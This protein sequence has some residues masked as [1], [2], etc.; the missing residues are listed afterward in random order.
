MRFCG[1]CSADTVSLSHSRQGIL[2]KLT[3][4]AYKN[5]PPLEEDRWIT[6]GKDANARTPHDGRGTGLSSIFG[7]LSRKEL[8][9]LTD[10]ALQTLL[11]HPAIHQPYDKDEQQILHQV[12]EGAE[13]LQHASSSISPSAGQGLEDVSHRPT[14]EDEFLNRAFDLWEDQQ[15]ASSQDFLNL[16]QML[17]LPLTQNQDE[18]KEGSDYP[19]APFPSG[20]APIPTHPL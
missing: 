5:V 10:T 17:H 11:R 1:N 13:L 2:G 6:E 9:C 15:L 19:S 8:L 16:S 14:A 20:C 18:G 4:S 12:L 3:T 7:N